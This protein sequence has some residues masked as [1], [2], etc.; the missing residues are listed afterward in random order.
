MTKLSEKQKKSL[1]GLAHG[2]DPLAR[3]GNPG[4]TASLVKEI[5]AQLLAHE[6]IKVKVMVGDREERDRIIERMCAATKAV[7]VQRIG[8]M[9]V[10]YKRHPKKPKIELPK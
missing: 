7:L 1:R 10:L 9:A 8:N 6:L 4:L 5:Q 3:V 2:K